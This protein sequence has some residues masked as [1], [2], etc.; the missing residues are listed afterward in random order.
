MNEIHYALG[1]FKFI[2]AY[3]TY[4]TMAFRCYDSLGFTTHEDASR[5]IRANGTYAT[6]AFRC[7]SSMRFTTH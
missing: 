4:A 5:F 2:G 3:G 7:Y 1:C 6:V